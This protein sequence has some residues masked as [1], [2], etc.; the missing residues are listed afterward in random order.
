MRKQN[1]L[2]GL[3]DLERIAE[4]AKPQPKSPVATA[5]QALTELFDTPLHPTQDRLDIPL[6]ILE[7]AEL[8]KV[9]DNELAGSKCIGASVSRPYEEEDI[10]GSTYQSRLVNIN[11]LGSASA[12]LFGIALT[13]KNQPQPPSI[14]DNIGVLIGEN[15][16]FQRD[17]AQPKT[18]IAAD[19]VTT[20]A[21]T[22]EALAAVK[23][24]SKIP[25]LASADARLTAIPLPPLLQEHLPPFNQKQRHIKWIQ[26]HHLDN[27]GDLSICSRAELMA[28]QNFGEVT[29]R[30]LA[31]ILELN[32]ATFRQ[33]T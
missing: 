18:F 15:T 27:V 1:P 12:R 30:S 9:G 28:L 14:F 11:R 23:V 7:A 26:S 25:G 19:T 6:G 10:D 8:G 5:H 24:F 31:K 16:V 21:S 20:E 33:D 4:A 17:T 13:D 3:Y 32:G 29:I 2:L 22:K